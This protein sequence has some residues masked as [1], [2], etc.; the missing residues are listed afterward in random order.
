MKFAILGAARS[1][2]APTGPSRLQSKSTSTD[3][4]SST[5]T[6]I[7]LPNNI[8]V[9]NKVIGYG[10][11]NSGSDDLS[12][13]QDNLGNAAATIVDTVS[14]G[15]L[16]KSW[17]YDVTVGGAATITQT[18]TG[19]HGFRG[20]VAHEV[21]GLATGAPEQ[22]STGNQASPGTGTDGITTASVTTVIANQYVFGAAHVNNTAVM[23]VTPGTSYKGV[24]SID[25][26]AAIS[27]L[28][29]EDKIQVPA[30][31]VAATFTQNSAQPATSCIMTFKPS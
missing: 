25:G 11:W 12:Q 6:A 10:F 8:A 30:G 14:N 21:T 17:W 13:I 27:P 2:K 4:T 24:E 29:S 1:F 9:G 28:E 22:H 20:L 15:D 16:Q 7:T 5:T 26:T 19:G 3:S 18:T 23:T 31:S